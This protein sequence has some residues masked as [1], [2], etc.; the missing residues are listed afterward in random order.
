[1]DGPIGIFSFALSYLHSMW[2]HFLKHTT[3]P[4]SPKYLCFPFIYLIL[5]NACY[6]ELKMNGIHNGDPTDRQTSP[7]QEH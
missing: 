7:E 3:A 1:M 4:A 6:I 2:L 5:E